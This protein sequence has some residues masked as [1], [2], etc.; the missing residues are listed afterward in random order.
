MGGIYTKEV[1]AF[2]KEHYGIIKPVTMQRRLK[3]MTGQDIHLYKISAKARRMGLEDIHAIRGTITAND[4]AEA[5]H[6][7]RGTV[8]KWINQKNLKAEKMK[9]VS[10]YIIDQEDFWKWAEHQNIDFSNYEWGS[11][12]PEP[13]LDKKTG[14]SWLHD[15]VYRCQK[16]KN[17]KSWPEDE[18]NLLICLKNRGL[19]YKEIQKKFP[20]KTVDQLM[21]KVHRLKAEGVNIKTMVYLPI[22][23]EE[24]ELMMQLYNKGYT[25]LSIGEE[26]SRS[27]KV[28][29]DTIKGM[30]KDE[31]EK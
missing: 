9:G 22:T 28:V 6:V 31:Q 4:L 3:K 7:T 16:E 2:M 15:A 8:Y 25:F 24:K 18:V 1:E 17:R 30:L 20:H 10:S 19:S 13:K 5:F 29:S 12:L 23:D 11:I 27:A 14:K 21:N 26:L